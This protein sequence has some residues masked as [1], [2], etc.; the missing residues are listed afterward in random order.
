MEELNN[1]KMSLR[2]KVILGI[3][4]VAAVLVVTRIGLVFKGDLT[5][6]NILSGGSRVL[7]VTNENPAALDSDKDGI[8]D[9]DEAYYQTD[10]FNSDTDGDSFKDGE[11]ITSKC[12]PVKPRP[13]DCAGSADPNRAGQNITSELSRLITAGIYSGDLK[14]P[15]TNQNF[16]KSLYLVK[17]QVLSDFDANYSPKISLSD[18]NTSQDNSFPAIGSYVKQLNSS[19]A[20]SLL[21]PKSEIVNLINSGLDISSA[22]E[23]RTNYPFLKLSDS[24]RQ[25]YAGLL[26]ME[27]PARFVNTHLELVNSMDRFA[28]AYEL[29]SNQAAD[30][31]AGVLSVEKLID[32]YNFSK[33]LAE[34]I[35][36]GVKDAL[37][38]T[39]KTYG[40][41]ADIISDTAGG[42]VPVHIIRDNPFEEHDKFEHP[43]NESVR[44]RARETL[45]EIQ[46]K[47]LENIRSSGRGGG[48]VFVQN[49]RQFLQ[50]GQYRGEDV[51][52][53][54]LADATFG[55]NPTICD[56]LREPLAKTF[57]ARTTIP[58]FEPSKYRVDS[59]QYF[60]I[61]NK[62]TL[63]AGFDVQKFREDFSYGG[64]AAWAR[65]ME[66]Q[67]NFFGLLANATAE[68]NKQ[69]VFEEQLDLNEANSG[70]GFL[71]RRS[72][73]K[74]DAPNRT[75]L[76]LGEI[77]TPGKILE[78][79]I[80]RTIDEDLSWLT[81]S[82]AMGELSA[83]VA[84]ALF[85]SLMEK[86]ENLS[87]NKTNSN[88]G[89]EGGGG[90]FGGGGS[91]GGF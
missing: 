80:Q 33:S 29:L 82:D 76:V 52:R 1:Q 56:Y 38:F 61:E 30:P 59:L 47:V 43:I 83:E 21:L 20:T 8:P 13:G 42:A 53:A 75:C 55:N 9:I 71:S 91:S 15:S 3:F 68:L 78:A 64:W 28:T 79:S 25:S 74:G 84:E 10:P 27:V 58:N 35:N 23:N 19:L 67:N 72:S 16:A 44:N 22:P 39:N 40:D 11:E 88:G 14:S 70:S 31:V 5:T 85:N 32:E 34:K 86:L 57:N 12:S 36:A 6:A 69:R 17:G 7:S 89:F 66:P 18:L 60:K 48:P 46:E 4:I 54:I 50:T 77:K 41:I 45:T 24:F 87:G 63:P 26:T 2:L 90:E 37:S 65:L 51:F 62:C 49:W 73:C 81:S